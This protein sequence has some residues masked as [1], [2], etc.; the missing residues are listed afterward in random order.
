MKQLTNIVFTRN[1]PLQLEAYL[2]SFYMFI[3]KEITNTV[4]LYKKDM[5]DEQYKQ[6]FDEYPDAEI[7]QEKD[8]YSDF[9]GLIK[10]NGTEYI[11]FGTD[12]VVYYDGVEWSFILQ[13]FEA[14]AND[15]FGFSLRFSPETLSKEDK[16]DLLQAETGNLYRINWKKAHSANAKYPFELNSTIYKTSLI[17]QIVDNVSKRH[18][19]LAKIFRAK[20]GITGILDKFISMKH[21]LIAIHSFKNPNDLESNCHRYCKRNKSKLPDNIYFKTLCASAIQIN[22]VNPVIKN[23]INPQQGFDI[24]SLNK[25]YIEGYRLDIDWLKNSKLASTHLNEQ[26][27]RLKN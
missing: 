15:I 14:Y 12:D 2:R 25:K 22:T 9:C 7:I 19:F 11:S 8:F 21:I 1:R 23:Q 18:P 16:Y 3:P 20:T 26:H 5:F 24:Y 17:K 13:T 4:I 27:F 6:L 10:K